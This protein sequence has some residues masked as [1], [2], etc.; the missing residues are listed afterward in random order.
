MREYPEEIHEFEVPVFRLGKRK[1][2]AVTVSH[3]LPETVDVFVGDG[4]GPIIAVPIKLCTT[5]ECTFRNW[6]SD[7]HR[8]LHQSQQIQSTT[9][10][11]F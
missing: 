7:E 6:L 4:H 10:L 3:A 2:D 9:T 8:D 11:N 1:L 5:R